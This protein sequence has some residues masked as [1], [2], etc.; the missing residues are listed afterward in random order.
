MDTE[1]YMSEIR[2]WEDFL[3]PV[4]KIANSR[5][6]KREDKY[7]IF[8]V[9][10]AKSRQ[11]YHLIK[12]SNKDTIITCGSRVSPQ[13]EIVANICKYL[14]KKCLCF[15]NNGAIT[16]E[17]QHAIDDGA[18]IVQNRKWIYNSV[19]IHHAKEY[20]SEHPEAEYIPFGMESW[21]GVRQT[22]YQ[23]KNIPDDV[24]NIVVV[25]GSGLNLCGILWGIKIFNR[26]IKVKAIRVGKDITQ[27]VQKYAP[28]DISNLEIID[29]PLD[30]HKEAK[31]TSI[32][33]IDLD[34]IYE[35]KCL[36]FIED[37][38]LFWIIGQRR[39]D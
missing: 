13:I 12:N 38:D 8:G 34:P 1:L 29:S 3:T 10:G 22:A 39:D 31:Q 21:E 9:C 27:L 25:A 37:G 32:D 23:L 28:S 35:A 7:Q 6:Y 20:C 17:L 33:T 36:P 2:G 26:D 24:K 18:T 15:T 14:G 30:Y 19:V 11:A 16:K 4:Q 5:Y